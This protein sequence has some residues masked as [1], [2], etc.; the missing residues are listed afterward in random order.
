MG[1]LL[2]YPSTSDLTEVTAP[3]PSFGD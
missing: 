2:V 3:G 1:W